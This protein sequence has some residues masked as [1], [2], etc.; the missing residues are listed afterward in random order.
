MSYTDFVAKDMTRLIVTKVLDFSGNDVSLSK[1]LPSVRINKH[2]FSIYG[3]RGKI[4]WNRKVF[5]QKISDIPSDEKA[6]KY[7]CQKTVV[8]IIENYSTLFTN[9]TNN[10]LLFL[11]VGEWLNDNT[12]EIHFCKCYKRK[13]KI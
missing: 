10:T 4:P 1:Q 12:Y 9:S 13:R 6:F 3:K 2:G 8:I 7:F 5:R 11:P